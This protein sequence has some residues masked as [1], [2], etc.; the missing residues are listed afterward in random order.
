M[1]QTVGEF[2]V[3]LKRKIFNQSGEIATSCYAMAYGKCVRNEGRHQMAALCFTNSA[4]LW[5][6]LTSV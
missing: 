6:R 5:W 1:L 2:D 4:L 3:H